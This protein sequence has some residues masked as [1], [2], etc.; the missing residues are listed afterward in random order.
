M[1][2]RRIIIQFILLF[3][4]VSSFFAED[5]IFRPFEIKNLAETSFEE[6][7]EHAKQFQERKFDIKNCEKLLAITATF[8]FESYL[9]ENESKTR[10]LGLIKAN[11][12]EV[13]SVKDEALKEKIVFWL[14]EKKNLKKEYPKFR[15]L[16][17]LRLHCIDYLLTKEKEAKG[18]LINRNVLSASEKEVCEKL[19]KAGDSSSYYSEVKKQLRQ[20]MYFPKKFLFSEMAKTK[21]TL[22]VNELLKLLLDNDDFYIRQNLDYVWM[23]IKAENDAINMETLKFA[24]ELWNKR[25]SLQVML[26]ENQFL[27]TSLITLVEVSFVS[28]KRGDIREHMKDLISIMGEKSFSRIFEDNIRAGETSEFSFRD[29]LSLLPL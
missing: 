9:V 13:G 10:D 29:E 20:R 24:I 17:N 11:E 16:Y 26:I 8:D 12:F 15:E 22:A 23:K 18:F 25:K 2:S 14:K 5:D 27:Q 6:L 21:G 19:S 7:K 1:G 4:S 3:S 28:F